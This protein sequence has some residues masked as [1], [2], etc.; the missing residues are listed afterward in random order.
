[1]AVMKIAATSFFSWPALSTCMQYV[2]HHNKMI[3]S[4]MN[5]APRKLISGVVRTVIRKIKETKNTVK[6]NSGNEAK[7]GT[8][9]PNQVK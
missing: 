3:L 4:R 5:C 7:R 6:L 9:K 2:P 1:M 8:K